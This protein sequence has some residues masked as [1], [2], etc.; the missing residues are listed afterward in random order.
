MSR[1][2]DPPHFNA[3]PDP[4]FDFKVDPDPHQSD[5]NLRPV[6]YRPSRILT[7]MR[8]RNTDLNDA[9]TQKVKF[10]LGV[11]IESCIILAPYN[12]LPPPPP[13]FH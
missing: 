9:E 4:I 10:Y 8:I 1:V 11:H 6:V 5:V 2:A 12:P 7:L 3:D 13:S